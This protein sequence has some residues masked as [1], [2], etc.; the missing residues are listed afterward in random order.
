M[1]TTSGISGASSTTG[2]GSSN[3]S[4]KLAAMSSDDFL[5][6]MLSELRNQDPFDPQDSGKLLDQ[7]SSLRNIQSQLSLQESLQS[8]VTQNQIASAGGMIGKIVRGLDSGNQEVTGKVTSVRV[9]DNMAMLE[10]D[11]GKLLEMGRVTAIANAPANA[12]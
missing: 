6:I 9:Q 3:A 7:M 2:T 11:N 4:D 1:A 10:L 12:A 5:K 8:L